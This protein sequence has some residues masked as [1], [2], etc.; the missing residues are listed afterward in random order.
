MW[1]GCF[2]KGSYLY[3]S[4]RPYTGF[5][6][7]KGTDVAG[8]FLDFESP[9]YSTVMGRVHHTDTET[10]IRL[11][12]QSFYSSEMP[13]KLSEPMLI[14]VRKP[15]ENGDALLG[16]YKGTFHFERNDSNH[17]GSINTINR[18]DISLILER[19]R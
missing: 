17:M 15:R 19:F 14:E 16:E 13:D 7:F 8:N 1:S 6:S 11:R 12:R 2:A 4:Q 5:I 9:R 18:G 10:I 3:G